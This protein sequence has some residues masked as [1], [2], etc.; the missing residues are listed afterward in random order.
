M[1]A[2]ISMGVSERKTVMKTAQVA[3]LLGIG[4]QRLHRKIL[5]G[6]YPVPPRDPENG[7]YLWTQTDVQIFQSALQKEP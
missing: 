2:F 4:R 1:Q 3:K 5:T 7:Y 6:R